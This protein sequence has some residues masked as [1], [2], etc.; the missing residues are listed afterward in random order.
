[1]WPRDWEREYAN[2]FDSSHL[3]FSSFFYS[4]VDNFSLSL[5]WLALN[6]YPATLEFLCNFFSWLCYYFDGLAYK[7]LAVLCWKSIFRLAWGRNWIKTT[8]ADFWK[9]REREKESKREK[10]KRVESIGKMRQTTMHWHTVYEW[11]IIFEWAKSQ[12]G[13]RKKKFSNN[14]RRPAIDFDSFRNCLYS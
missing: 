2:R 1:M 3:L 7:L 13:K 8:C 4:R 5:V 9:E 14:D 12:H 11:Y 6:H 10:M